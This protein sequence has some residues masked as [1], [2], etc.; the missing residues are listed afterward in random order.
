M[1]QSDYG[2]G[3]IYQRQFGRWMGKN[4]P[5]KSKGTDAIHVLTARSS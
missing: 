1:K 3:S 4:L 2:K 5:A